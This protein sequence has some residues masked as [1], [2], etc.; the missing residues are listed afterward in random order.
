MSDL[1]GASGQSGEP[2]SGP[3]VADAHAAAAIALLRGELEETR[4]QLDESLERERAASEV[5]GVISRSKFAI[6]PVLDTIVV[7]AIRLC[8]ADAASMYRVIDGRHHL[9]AHQG[10]SDEAVAYRLRHPIEPGRGT[11]TGRAMLEGRRLHIPDVLADPEFDW[12]SGQRTGG[13]RTV[14]SVPLSS[15]GR[16]LGV[17]SLV[18]RQV[19]PFTDKQIELVTT[20]ADQAVIAIQNVHLFD[21]LQ[22]R[23]AELTEALERQTATS[24]VLGVISRSKFD[25]QPVLDT[26]CRTARELCR[27]ESATIVLEQ[28]GTLR[29]AAT[30]NVDPAFV[31]FLR[32]NPQTV[33]RGTVMGRAILDRRT[34]HIEDAVEDAAYTWVDGLKAGHFRTLLGVP[35]LRAGEPIGAI[36]LHRTKV[37]PYSESQIELVTTFADQA[38]IAIENVRLFDEV[39]ARTRELMESLERQT[40]TSDVLA[41]ISRSKFDIQPVLDTI[42]VTAARLCN[43][44]LADI[45]RHDG[46]SY[47][48]M[49]MFGYDPASSHFLLSHPVEPDSSSLQG[50]VFLERRIVHIPDCLADPDYRWLDGQRVLGQ[51]SMLGVPL[52]RDGEMVGAITLMRRRVEPFSEKQIEVVSTFA[53]QA[54]IAIENV[55]LFEEVQ[56]RTR[57]LGEALQQQTATAEVLKIISRSTFD[58]KTVLQTLVESAARLCEADKA[59]V[60]RRIDGVLYRAES[61]G[62]SPEFMA[63]MRTLPIVPERGTIS[64]RVLLEGRTVHIHDVWKDPDY[65]LNETQKFDVHRTAL[66][67]PLIREGE[68]I[69]VMVL[70]RTNVR[71]FTEK[72][73]ELVNTFADQAAIA[74]E[75]ARLF[76]SEQERTRELGRSLEELRAA[77]DRLVQTEKLASLGQ[78][79]AGIAHEI[80]NP[81]NFINNFGQLSSELIDELRTALSGVPLD[82]AVRGEVDELSAMLRGNLDKVV[83]HGKRADSIVKNMLMH[84]RQGSGERR[85]VDVNAVV[86]E[87]LNLAYHGARAA[88]RDFNVTLERGFDAAAGKAELCPQE[89]T[90]VLLNLIGNGFYAV[91][92]RKAAAGG[93]FEPKLLAATRDLGASVELRI[94]DNGTGIPAAVRER[95]FTPFFTT[96]PAGE[97]T[98]LGLSL[99]HDIVVKQ[100]GGTIDVDSAPGEFTEFRIVLPRTA[101]KGSPA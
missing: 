29:L 96:K 101:P 70:T 75:N 99:S 76:E 69:G 31:A 42:V 46:H 56:A 100:H 90:R 85:L 47:Q 6:Q 38:V 88:Q 27:S 82:G 8:R 23:T 81:L 48:T 4:R 41:V 2:A 62:F 92:K 51:R 61:Y 65:R 53:D 91:A 72:Q 21:E 22:A 17:I 35:L 97:G 32:Q 12:Y 39:Q 1:R 74:I 93:D 80:K 25:L 58:L 66:G 26:I 34:V 73:I 83:Q 28:S 9:V 24:E 16:I 63:F 52:L 14:L 71:P 20:F 59:I 13:S 78:L 67:V 55:R 49:A 19:A 30:A 44:E 60:T 86:E 54:V 84:S 37:S 7:A 50:R 64:S 3:V 40:A 87:S 77:Q 15:D 11:V 95:L 5:L 98:G 10:M 57:E 94:R 36:V 33:H 43:A 68:V 18:R 89:I 45:A 79:T